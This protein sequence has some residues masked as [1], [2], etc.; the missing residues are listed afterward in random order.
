VRRFT[1]GKSHSQKARW[2]SSASHRDTSKQFDFTHGKKADKHL[3]ACL[4]L[5]SEDPSATCPAASSPVYLS[6]CDRANIH[7]ERNSQ[8][9]LREKL[10][11][12][13]H[14]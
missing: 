11:A 5:P 3:T 7:H 2:K 9:L 8:P 12:G 14:H 4:M 6:A 1:K 10:P 13:H